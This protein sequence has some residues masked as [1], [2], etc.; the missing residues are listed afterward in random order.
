MFQEE[1]FDCF[2]AL[3]QKTEEMAKSAFLR[4]QI[5]ALTNLGIPAKSIS[6]FLEISLATVYRHRNPPRGVKKPRKV[7]RRIEKRR[8]LVCS[9]VR[10]RTTVHGRVFPQFCSASELT[11]E[12]QKKKVSASRWTVWRDLHQLGFRSVV[13]KRV[14]TRDPVVLKKRLDFCSNWLRKGRNMCRKIVFSDEHTL[15]IN[16]HTKRR[17]YV[18]KGQPPIPRERRRLQNIPRVQVWAA[19]GID[20]K[21]PIVLFPQQ[22]SN[23]EDFRL[24]HDSYIRRCL[25][26]I[27]GNIRGRIFQQDGARPHVHHSVHNYLN[28]KGIEYIQ[29]WPPYSPDINCAEL[30]WPLLN[31]RVAKQHPGTLDELTQAIRKAWSSITQQEINNR[32]EG[33]FKQAKTVVKNGGCA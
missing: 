23:A 20:Y 7:C 12:L 9:L 22:D 25:S 16:D 31:E 5:T 32:C 6:N 19:V 15:S 13:R 11:D 29:N 10:R 17:M 1:E 24:K 28:A 33:F 27:A 26:L 8:K 4:G 2:S 21:S 18:K 14:P 3:V 30:I